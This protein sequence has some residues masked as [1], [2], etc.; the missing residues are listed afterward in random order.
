MTWTVND[1]PDQSER[2]VLVTGANSGLGFE[3]TKALLSKGAKVIMGC[4]SLEKGQEA[5]HKLLQKG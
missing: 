4:R 3:T 5:F 2:I 1:I